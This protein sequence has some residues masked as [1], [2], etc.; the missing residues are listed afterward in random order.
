MLERQSNLASEQHHRAILDD[1]VVYDGDDG[2]FDVTCTVTDAVGD[3][4]TERAAVVVHNVPPVIVG[5][6][7]DRAVE[8]RRYVFA[9]EAFDPVMS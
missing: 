2:T 8:R 3:T 1:Q 9:P 4:A 7:P 5:V 6:P